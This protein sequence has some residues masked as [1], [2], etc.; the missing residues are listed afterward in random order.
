MGE[1]FPFVASKR[2]E[3]FAKKI[4]ELRKVY[5][6]R[7]IVGIF[8]NMHIFGTY[9]DSLYNQLRDLNPIRCKL[10]EADMF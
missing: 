8:G 5:S 4:M 2:D 9:G 1:I 3:L 7:E 6:E 10:K